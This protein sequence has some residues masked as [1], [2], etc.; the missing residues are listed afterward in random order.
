MAEPPPL[1][2]HSNVIG[3]VY[4]FGPDRATFDPPITLCFTYNDSLIPARVAEDELV[5]AMWVESAEGADKWAALEVYT[6]DTDANTICAS[7][8]HFTAFT[9]LTYAR[10]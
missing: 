7:V 2:E 5:I 1:P 10:L 6:I 4:D 9:I 3:L 8:N